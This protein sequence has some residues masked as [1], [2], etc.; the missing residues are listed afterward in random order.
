MSRYIDAEAFLADESEAYM[1]AQFKIEDEA[2][3]DLNSLVHKKIQMIIAY[4]P[5]A[6]VVEVV[7]CKECKHWSDY[8]NP[9]EHT[10]TCYVWS[11]HDRIQT[12][13]EQWCCYG[14]RK[15]E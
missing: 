8:I 3:R 4:A 6:D 7:R 12:N 5:T 15:E 10:A 9:I 2:T 14:E 13:G 11:G 1:S